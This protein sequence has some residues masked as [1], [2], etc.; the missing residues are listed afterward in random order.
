MPAAAKLKLDENLGVRGA[1]ILR[2]AG[3]DVATVPEQ[4][5]ESAS[6]RQLIAACQQEARCLVTLDLDFAN[7][8][9]FEPSQYAG[10]VVLRLPRRAAPADLDE[11]LRTLSSGLARDDVRGHLWI[12]QR[13]RIRVYQPPD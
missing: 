7:P 3:H 4:H 2:Q 9:L 12:V 1:S 10:I 5:L 13:T 8:L 6:D 11:A